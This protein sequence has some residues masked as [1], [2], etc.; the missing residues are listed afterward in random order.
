MDSTGHIATKSTVQKLQASDIE[1]PG[2]RSTQD[3]M[4]KSTDSIFKKAV[5]HGRM[6]HMKNLD[7]TSQVL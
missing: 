7:F 2:L 6:S 5:Q 1:D 3:F 4:S